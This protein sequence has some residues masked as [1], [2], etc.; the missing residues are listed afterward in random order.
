MVG[1]G[2]FFELPPA[3]R[4]ACRGG[5]LQHGSQIVRGLKWWQQHLQLSS[6]CC[7]YARGVPAGHFTHI[8]MDEVRWLMAAWLWRRWHTQI[9]AAVVA[10]A[11]ADD[12]DDGDD[13]NDDD[14]SKAAA[15]RCSAHWFC[16]QSAVPCE[17]CTHEKFP[18]PVNFTPVRRAM[19]RSPWVWRC[20]L[21][22][23]CRSTLPAL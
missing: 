14:H 11:V 18:P 16:A 23:T 21:A 10:A 6:N 5:H 9:D 15:A 4:K 17:H 19:S 13:D 20:W 1:G 12:Y 22:S 7:R 3:T 2:R 8:L